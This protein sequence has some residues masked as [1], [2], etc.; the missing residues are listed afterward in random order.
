M[1]TISGQTP[2]HKN[3]KVLT[4]NRANGKLFPRNNDQF[5][6]W[7]QGA[8]I[9][10]MNQAKR[11]FAGAV[12]IEMTF[13][14]KDRRPR[15]LDNMV[16]SVLDVLSAPKKGKGYGVGVITGDDVFT[17]RGIHASFGGV[18]RANPRVEILIC[19]LGTGEVKDG[20]DY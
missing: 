4:L 3:S 6:R 14:I 11:R 19:D 13:F 20:E 1:I 10:I 2:S 8:E 5:M 7:V 12:E 9:D 17:V 18:D 15:D 16:A